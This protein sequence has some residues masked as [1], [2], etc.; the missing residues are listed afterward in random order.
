MR[1]GRE[2]KGRVGRYSDDEDED[3]NAEGFAD[4]PAARAKPSGGGG[5]D[6]SGL[7]GERYL[8]PATASSMKTPTS[9]PQPQRSKNPTVGFM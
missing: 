5:R 7:G 9:P 6:S 8:S 1:R 3:D 4:P 2:E